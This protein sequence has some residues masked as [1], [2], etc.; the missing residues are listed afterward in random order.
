[1][2]DLATRG[3]AVTGVVSGAAEARSIQRALESAT[4]AY[5]AAVASAQER[6]HALGEASLSVVQLA[7]RSD[8][9]A[10]TAQAA[11]AIAAAKNGVNTC[12]DEVVPILGVIARRFDA[13]N[14]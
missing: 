11:E 3:Q 14:S 6:I 13:R 4:Q 2:S 7:G 8:V 12:R 10:A 5:A 1:M 9:G